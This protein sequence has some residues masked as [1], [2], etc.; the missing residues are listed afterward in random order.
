MYDP[1]FPLRQVLPLGPYSSVISA[2]LYR[3]RRILVPD[4]ENLGLRRSLGLG[5]WSL[6]EG[7]VCVLE[8]CKISRFVRNRGMIE[9]L[10]RL[11]FDQWTLHVTYILITVQVIICGPPFSRSNGQAIS[12]PYAWGLVF[13]CEL[14]LD[15]Y[16]TQNLGICLQWKFAKVLLL[17]FKLAHESLTSQYV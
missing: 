12:R 10:A 8:H 6:H 4:Q 15:S 3:R 17:A 5:P 1:A 9:H 14:L 13:A 11:G 16:T 2:P 7:F